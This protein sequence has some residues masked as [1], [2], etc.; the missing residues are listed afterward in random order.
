MEHTAPL[1]NPGLTLAM[2][3][4]AGMAAQVI[5]RHLRVPGIVLLLAAGVLLGPD[6][7][8]LVRPS[9]LGEGLQ[10]LV[11]FAVAIIL[12]EGGL[13]LDVK[14]LRREATA[15]RRLV[16]WGALVTA[17]GGAVIARTILGWNWILSILFGTL[18]IV[19]GPTVVNPLLR[20]IRVKRKVATVLE[21]E[22]VFIDAIGAITAVVALELVTTS[23]DEWWALVGS[24][25]ARLLFGAIVG[26]LGGFL[27]VILLRREG[28]VPE[29]L[30]NVFTLSVV[31]ALYQASDALFPESGIATVTVAGMVVGNRGLHVQ[32]ELREFKEQLT[33]MFIAVLF[34]LL[35]AD[36]R[37]A[38]VRDLGWPGVAAVAALIFLIRPLTVAVSTIGQ[39]FDWRERAFLSWMAPR[40]IVAAAVASLFALRLD[41]AGIAG[42]TELRAMVFLVI[43]LTVLHAGL[44]GGPMA[45]LLGLRLQEGLGYVILGASALG[46]RL[47]RRLESGG[48]EAVLVDANPTACRAAEE[49]GLRVVYGS[50]LDERVLERAGLDY[51]VGAVGATANET[52]NF[53]F[54]RRARMEHD[55]PRVWVALRR[56]QHLVSREMVSRIG[57]HTLFGRPR[58]L[59]RWASL[60]E[61]PGAV[62]EE[63]WEFPKTGDGPRLASEFELS[64]SAGAPELGLLP[65]TVESNGRERLAD[66]ESRPSEGDAVWWL[67]QE[68]QR[69]QAEEWLEERGLRRVDPESRPAGRVDDEGPEKRTGA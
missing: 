41:H 22:G 9:S 65:L 21:A 46:R 59:E 23:A 52:V 69:E 37:L 7:A 53:A 26:A 35:A 30:E 31:L 49:A 27:I 8:D 15:I 45:S 67:V 10:I 24:G 47:A 1:S 56:D 13:S 3:L 48:E 34:V 61:R 55:V 64:A 54:A 58:A 2:A 44:T 43:A 42:G 4:V 66:E 11:G 63:R 39:G 50:G 68:S 19:T 38:D 12:F 40:G 62:A 14:E 51:C 17:T 36:V 6:V 33:T 16:T 28:L 25:P 5:A 60:L 20:R 29:G 32:E 57:A 18:V